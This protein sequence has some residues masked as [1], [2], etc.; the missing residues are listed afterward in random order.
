MDALPEVPTLE[1]FPSPNEDGSYTLS[2]DYTEQLAKFV[3]VLVSYV[4][5][6]YSRCGPEAD[7]DNNE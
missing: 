7:A 5:E 6:Q 2:K 3:Y 4:E 1:P